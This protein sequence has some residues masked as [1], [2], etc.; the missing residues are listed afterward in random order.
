MSDENNGGNAPANNPYIPP[1]IQSPMPD[2]Y[3]AEGQG[4][5]QPSGE[6]ENPARNAPEPKPTP[7]PDMSKPPAKPGEVRVA[8]V[9]VDPNEWA[10]TQ[11]RMNDLMEFKRK[12]QELEDM[13]ESERVRILAEK[14]QVEEALK[15]TTERHETRYKELERQATE[16]KSRWLEERRDSVI[17]DALTGK[18]FVGTDPSRTAAML[19]RLLSD[20]VEAFLDSGGKPA[21]RDRTTMRPAAE[22]LKERLESPEYAVFFA[23]TH[24]GG[25]GTDGTRAPAA[26]DKTKGSDP[27]AEFAAWFLKQKEDQRNARF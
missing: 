24:R 14:G 17:N 7:H 26:P 5:G 4:Q 11:S 15:I 27:N 21:V 6:R 25:A 18:Q 23:A 13:R 9:W 22:Y 10:A 1:Q 20:E 3:R 19:R 16:M 12:S 8:P 2:L